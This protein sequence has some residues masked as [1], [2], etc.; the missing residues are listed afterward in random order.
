[1]GRFAEGEA[2]LRVALRSARAI[3][4]HKLTSNVLHTLALARFLSGDSSQARE[5]WLDAR[6][7]YKANGSEESA[8]SVAL[9]L[10]ELEFKDGALEMAIRLTREAATEFAPDPGEAR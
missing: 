5:F 10:A 9:N 6:A 3:G 7:R 4:A 8:A 1:M 2:Q